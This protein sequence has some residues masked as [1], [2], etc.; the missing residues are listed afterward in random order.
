MYGES[1]DAITLELSDLEKSLS[2]SL[3]FEWLY[4]VMEVS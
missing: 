4:F 3:R 1:I 2:R